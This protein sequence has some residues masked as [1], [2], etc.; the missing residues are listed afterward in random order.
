[1]EKFEKN[2]ERI[3]KLNISQTNV[4]GKEQIIHQKKFEENNPTITLNV[5]YPKKKKFIVSMV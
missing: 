5:L 2:S 3:T 1:M 4:I